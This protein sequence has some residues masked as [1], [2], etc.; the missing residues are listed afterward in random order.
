M[1]HVLLDLD[2]TLTDPEEGITA[3]IRYALDKLGIAAPT[4]TV[5]ASYIGPPLL[6]TFRKL[7]RT[8]HEATEG[9]RLYRERFSTKGLY[10]NRV[11]EGIVS[12]LEQ[13]AAAG[14]T[15]CVATS[16]PGV[17][18]TRIVEHFELAHFFGAVYGSELDGRLSDKTE[19]IA[20]ILSTEGLAADQ[21]VMIGDRRYDVVGANNHGVRSVGVLWGFGS[22]SELRDAG[23]NA[24]CNRPDALFD[25]VS[26]LL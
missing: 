15:L 8:E 3:C 11:Y 12:A 4:D 26:A 9:V 21:A 18:A 22:E 7:C 1:A 2:G 23:A 6:H 25:T 13:F 19:L 20:H 17:Y 10:E 16:K 14:Y 24:L 5:L